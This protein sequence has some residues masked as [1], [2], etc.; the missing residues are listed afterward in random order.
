M[1]IVI[2]G[3]FLSR[4]YTGFGDYTIGLLKGLAKIDQKNQYII[5]T[6][7]KVDLKLP[8]NFKIKVIIPCNF[9]GVA[10]GKLWWEQF[11]IMWGAKKEKCDLVHHFYPVTSVLIRSIPQIN[12][13]HDVIPWN[14]PGYNY[15]FL[16]KFLRAFTRWSAH[17]ADWIVTVSETSKQDIAKTFNLPEEKICVIYNGYQK[18]FDKK[19]SAPLIKK[20]LQKYKIQRQYIFYLGGFDI[21]K[22]VRKLVLAYKKIAPGLK[23]DLILAGGV[24]SPQRKIY[25]DYYKMPALIKKIGLEKRV[26]MIGSVESQHLPALYQ[27]ASIFVSPT[28]AEGFNIPVLEAF[29]S[30]TAVTCSRASATGEV[31]QDAALKFNS[32]SIEEIADAIYSLLKDSA[33]REKYI[34]AGKVRAADFSWQKS[35]EKLLSLYLKF[36]IIRHI[37]TCKQV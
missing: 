16:A 30:G 33:L 5:F 3:Y 20:V 4:P 37:H 6:S 22:N 1:K 13:I 8:S 34:L 17:F 7:A 11:Q 21:R 19:L 26:K 35:A 18:Q 12:S 2:N 31:A 29:A 23:Q 36:N 10:L 24:F 25:D 32:E 28:M 15:S 9:F 27:G 14:F